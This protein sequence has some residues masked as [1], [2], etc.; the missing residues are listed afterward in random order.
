M[1]IDYATP[2]PRFDWRGGVGLLIW[3]IFGNRFFFSIGRFSLKKSTTG[4]VVGG[5]KKKEPKKRTNQ[6]NKRRSVVQPTT[7]EPVDKKKLGTTRYNLVNEIKPGN[8]TR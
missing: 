5:A 3:L 1:L 8:K 2:R 6:N 7:A 4:D